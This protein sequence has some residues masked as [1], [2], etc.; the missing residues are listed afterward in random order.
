MSGNEGVSPLSSMSAAREL[1]EISVQV[2]TTGR[3]VEK[4]DARLDK[5]DARL[6]HIGQQV[7]ATRADQ[8]QAASLVRSEFHSLRERIEAH[9]A[10]LARETLSREDAVKRVH[11]LYGPVKD[12]FE[13][14]AAVRQADDRRRDL[15]EWAIRVFLGASAIGAWIY[16]LTH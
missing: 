11:D 12:D 13:H 2:K 10:A 8:E 1:G 9:G 14:R 3:L 16:S 4:L 7:Q 15:S 6:E 5:Q